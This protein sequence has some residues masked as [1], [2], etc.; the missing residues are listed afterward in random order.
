MT[1]KKGGELP[2]PEVRAVRCIPP[3]IQQMPAHHAGHHHLLP[4]YNIHPPMGAL[5][6]PEAP[7]APQPAAP[8]RTRLHPHDPAPAAREPR[9]EPAVMN[10]ALAAQGSNTEP[11]RV[12]RERRAEPARGAVGAPR[13]AEARSDWDL[14]LQRGP[15][16][17]GGEALS[18]VLEVLQVAELGHLRDHQGVEE[19]D[20]RYCAP[21]KGRRE[22]GST[23]QGGG[24]P[25]RTMKGSGRDSGGMA[26]P[27]AGVAG[28]P[29]GG[30]GTPRQT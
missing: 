12:A 28:F 27:G 30:G 20:L 5:I 25:G 9:A 10:P 23:P 18:L 21:S 19:P 24:S 16:P 29:G 11:A 15:Q 26:R 13:P 8:P 4:M 1:G 6:P 22:P 2:Q 17:L 3:S 7:Q 14:G